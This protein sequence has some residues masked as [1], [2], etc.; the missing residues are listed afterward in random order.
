MNIRPPTEFAAWNA[1]AT[2]AAA[3]CGSALKDA[4][5]ADPER[6]RTLAVEAPGLRFDYS[7]QRLDPAVIARLV[8]LAMARDLPAW[9]GALLAG[10][11]VND[12]EQRPAWHS[13]LR[14]GA[15]APAE[16][17]AAHARMRSLAA[18]LR[19]GTWQ[20]A[21]GR[22]IRHIVHLGTGGSDLGPRL[23]V[24]ALAEAATPQ[25]RIG[26]A[27]NVDPLDLERA[28]RDADP[29]TTLLVV[30]SKTFTTQ[31]TMEN[32]HAAKAWLARGLPAGAALAPHVV[33]V[34]ANVEAARAFGAGEVL[35]MWDWVGGRYSVWSTVGFS[36]MAAL[37]EA[38]FS[39]FLAGAADMDA[40]FAAAPLERNVPALMG[41]IGVWNVN[42][43][44]AATHVVLPYATPLRLLPAYLQQLEMESNGKR[45]DRA[46]RAVEYA[47]APVVWG[48][49]G[50]VGQHSFH[51]LLHQGTQAVPAD[52]IVFD[53]A[54][55]DRARRAILAAHAEAQA[56]ALARG[57][58][59]PALPAY[60]R[61]P[62]GRPSSTLRFERLDARNLGR[63]I[64]LYE[65]KVFTQGV[66]WNINSF[67]QWG[68]ELGKQLAKTLL[69]KGARRAQRR[70]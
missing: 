10:E 18:R 60:R 7:R 14:A 33:A 28:L 55:G 66:I 23:V 16:V 9:R 1:L 59:D 41:L 54:P 42:F 8:E 53:D 22:A 64:A 48:A 21:T 31:E 27:A 40:H 38:A 65:H 36:A 58:D 25:L 11:A 20:G 63:L 50:T 29:Q 24:D 47:T 34:S 17:H 15:A 52:F 35:P 2:H 49:E 45:V 37:G 3:W 70:P 46:G 26:F 19:E 67:D 56:E 5:A 30:V 57:A 44:G 4:L 69:E 32:A 43:L 13:A 68:V 39:E 51:Q 61:Y 12:T 6:A 62:G